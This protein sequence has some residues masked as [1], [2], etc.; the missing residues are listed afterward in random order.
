M[1]TP[2]TPGYD[3][4]LQANI[5]VHARLAA[6]YDETE[7]HFR[8]EN[9]AVVDGRLAT[10][11]AAAGSG[12]MLDLGCG[13]GFMIGIGKRYFREI[14]GVDATQE[15][16]DRVDVSGP[17]VIRLHRHDTGTFPVREREYDVVTAYSF[18]HHLRDVRPTLDT[19]FR[20][21][22]SGGRLYVDLEPNYYFW[23]GVSSLDRDGDHDPIVAREIAEVAHKDAEMEERYGIPRAVFNAAEYGK[24]IG[25]GF[26]EE[27][28]RDLTRDVGFSTVE[29]FYYWFLGQ[30][31]L[32]NDSRYGERAERLRL[33]G[34]TDEILRKT[35]PLSRGLYKYLG[36]VAVK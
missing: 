11:A 26:K 32:V 3:A 34:V 1:T 23:A 16:L 5:A 17:A 14:D 8:P 9:V 30:A 28:L 33:A 25:G 36:L 4:V 29:V 18:L 35:L 21:L 12:R 20:G 24:A 13:T 31:T 15:M 7:P 10:V 19:A 2:S 22:K 27:T 6:V